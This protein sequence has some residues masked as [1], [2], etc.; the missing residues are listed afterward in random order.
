VSK[1]EIAS[2]VAL[3]LAICFIFAHP[4]PPRVPIPQAGKEVS[5]K[6]QTERLIDPTSF[7]L[8]A[9]DGTVCEVPAPIYAVV[10]PGHEIACDWR[11]W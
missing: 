11:P 9:R 2:L 7:Y 10:Q 5:G 1:G 6:F 4:L 3:F 8:V